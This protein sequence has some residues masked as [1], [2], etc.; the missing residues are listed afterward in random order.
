MGNGALGTIRTNRFPGLQVP[1]DAEMKKTGRGSTIEKSTNVDGVEVR[2]IKWYDNRGV[3]LA[4]SFG[5]ARLMFTVKRYGRKMKCNVDI[6]CPRTLLYRRDCHIQN[7]PKK[8]I[9]DLLQFKIDV[10]AASCAQGKDP[11]EKKRG[12]PSS[13]NVQEGHERKKVAW[14]CKT[15]S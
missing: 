1:L 11:S 14:S 4:S 7:F 8:L 2:V 12:T 3:T 10:A 5:S 13:N 6:P 9:V 15:N